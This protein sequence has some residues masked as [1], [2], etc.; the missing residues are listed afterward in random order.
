MRTVT[1]SINH[2]T[3]ED[4]GA[5][6]CFEIIENETRHTV[7]GDETESHCVASFG[8]IDEARQFIERILAVREA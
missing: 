6:D 5:G 7:T 8:T 3:P 4:T 1:Y 2:W